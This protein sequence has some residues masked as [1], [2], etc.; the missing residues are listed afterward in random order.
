M[1]YELSDDEWTA[2]KPILSNKPRSVRRVNDRRVLDG[3]FWVLRSGASRRDLPENHGLHTTRHGNDDGIVVRAQRKL[4]KRINVIWV[5][6]SS[7]QKY[8]TSPVGQIIS[9]NSRH[10]TPPEGRI[11]IVTDAGCGCGGRGSVLRAMGSQGE[12]KDS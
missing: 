12:S 1:R 2:I 8:F 5:V 3:I 9:T 6:Q 11:A 4:L 10:P 7:L